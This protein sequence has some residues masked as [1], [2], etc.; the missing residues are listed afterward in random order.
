MNADKVFKEHAPVRD[1]DL[2][3]RRGRPECPSL[4]DVLDTNNI[5]DASK[6]KSTYQETQYVA[7][8]VSKFP[9]L[10]Y[11]NE[12]VT[13]L[14][15]ATVR[16]VAQALGD[17]CYIPDNIGHAYANMSPYV[18]DARVVI[19]ALLQPIP[20]QRLVPNDGDGLV[21]LHVAPQQTDALEHSTKHR[22][23][24]I[25]AP[26][27]FVTHHYRVGDKV[28]KRHNG[29]LSHLAVH[30]Y[31]RTFNSASICPEQPRHGGVFDQYKR[32]LSS[33]WFV[34]TDSPDQVELEVIDEIIAS[35]ADLDHSIRAR[36]M[37]LH[38]PRVAS[39]DDP[40]VINLN[41][42]LVLS[43]FSLVYTR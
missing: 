3:Q 14:M 35:V 11:A 16:S 32:R 7:I 8:T 26:E 22:L 1:P 31:L 41:A 34:W 38:D 43:G 21:E 5:L 33:F 42:L 13:H 4:L 18:S 28:I 30:Y 36:V 24:A 9:M 40:F 37:S 27:L 39:Q 25:D 19:P 15:D 29:H 10:A 12:P 6:A 17:S 2:V 23:H 20:V